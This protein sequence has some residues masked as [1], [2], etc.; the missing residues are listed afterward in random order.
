[1][2]DV[3]ELASHLR[4]LDDES[5][6]SICRQSLT[7][8]SNAKDFFDLAEQLLQPRSIDSWLATQNSSKLQSLIDGVG[9]QNINDPIFSI[10]RK[11]TSNASDPLAL[12][13][14]Q[15]ISAPKSGRT[16]K[17]ASKEPAVGQPLDGRAADDA[18]IRGFLSI[19]GLTEFVIDLEHRYLREVGK[20][21]LAL[22]DVK[23]FGLHLG[24]ALDEVR[25][26]WEIARLNDL[27]TTNQSRWLLGDMAVTWLGGTHLQRWIS[28]TTLWRELMA[29]PTCLEIA[30]AL[31]LQPKRSFFETLT[32]IFPLAD[33]SPGSKEEKLC[34]YAEMI[35]LTS[36]G[37]AQPWMIAALEGKI[38]SAAKAIAKHMPSLQARVILQ[39]DLSIVAPG[40]LEVSAEER[41]REFAQ[42]EAIGLAS[43]FRLTPL[44]VSFALERGHSI[45]E[46][47][48]SLLEL[49][50][51]PLPQ[52]V[53]YLL[54]DVLRRFGRIKVVADEAG[55][56]AYIRVSDTTLAIEL[57][58]DLRHRIISLRQIDATTLYSKYTADVVYFTLRDYG[59]LAV[60][61]NQ[62]DSVISPER[63]NS[64]S[65]KTAT[66]DP[67]TALVAKL[68]SAETT[69]ADGENEM[70]L[71]QLQ[72][73]IKNKSAILVTYVGKD[74]TEHRFLLEPV[75]ISNGRLRSRDKKAD[76]ERTLPLSNIV[77]LELA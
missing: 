43:H 47:R 65:E 70:M 54:N 50:G 48:A 24:L 19:Q 49:S 13:I 23:R 74:G 16:L 67:V 14:G 42:A 20:F 10:I 57:A 2:S 73:A 55:G 38:D 32:S 29:G 3:L 58:K 56:G 1:M 11:R 60:R 33:A 64:Q 63:I 22:P 6:I 68:R 62:D 28:A 75:A 71:R 69:S 72:L 31:K 30:Q 66:V 17:T 36:N 51:N 77:K 12:K 35:G 52:P 21:G 53:E 59:H 25:D 34:N 4:E 41:L 39:T 40:P 76:I 9:V 8:A 37:M 18:G 46:I 15:A 5:L 7:Q 27:T 45:D 61:A 44:S 26:L